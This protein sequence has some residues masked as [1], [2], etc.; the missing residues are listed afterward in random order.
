LGGAHLATEKLAVYALD[1]S[2]FG[3]LPHE[4][5]A[6]ILRLSRILYHQLTAIAWR[7]R[8]RDIVACSTEADLCGSE[9]ALTDT[10]DA[11]CHFIYTQVEFWK[12]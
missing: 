2:Y 12:G 4:T 7:R 8:I 1:R 6:V 10:E 5:K 3:A 9:G 11:G